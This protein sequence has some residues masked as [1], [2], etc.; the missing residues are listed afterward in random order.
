[1]PAPNTT[2][3][4]WG[5]VIQLGKETVYGVDVAATRRSFVRDISFNSAGTA[6]LKEYAT[7]TRDQARDQTLGSIESSG[8]VTF[9]MS[10]DE[11]IEW[12]QMTINK[13]NELN[14]TNPDEGLQQGAGLAYR[15]AYVPGL[16]L[17]SA[18]VERN[19]GAVEKQALGTYVNQMRVQGSATGQNV[20]TCD[21]FSKS[22]ED[23]AMTLSGGNLLP[24]RT[25]RELEGWQTFFYLADPA[26][27]LAWIDGT[28]AILGALISWDI[29]INNNLGRKYHAQNSQNLTRVTTGKFA[30]QAT[31]VGEASHAS[32][33][34]EYAKWLAQNKRLMRLE[35]LGP[36]NGIET[37]KRRFLILDIPGKWATVDLNQNDAGTRAYQFQMN[38]IYDTTSGVATTFRALAQN[39]RANSW[40]N[41]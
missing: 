20:V 23:A 14:P 6:N 13:D 29:T 22:Y 7:G 27:P 25:I 35:F 9:D 10:P 36:A 5:E 16:E 3:E 32:I 34:A 2:G 1:M 11:S 8:S 17:Q 28:G 38:A 26:D 19:D 40:T 18:V 41:V 37:G 39:A 31:I 30:V 4:L 12:L 21:L 33:K 15:W 24:E